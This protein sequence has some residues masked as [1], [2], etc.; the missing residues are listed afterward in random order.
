MLC[1]L[2]MGTTRMQNP[3]E[4]QNWK[5][6]KRIDWKLRT[7][8]EPTS[9]ANFYG[10][11]KKNIKKKFQLEI[12]F[13][14]F[15]REKKHI[16]ANLRKRWFSQ[17]KVQYCLPNN[18]IILVSITNFEPNSVL[19]NVNKLKPYTYVDQTLKG[20]QNSKDKKSLQF[21]DEEYMEERYDE[22]LEIQGK[23]DT[24]GTN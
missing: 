18:F 22:E 15:P 10:V 16:W 20:I 13:Y 24:I 4:L 12:M 7:M 2:L 11:N 14:G 8:W 17:F 1:H 19:V 9:G 23:T 6:Y 5:S 3:L 21:I